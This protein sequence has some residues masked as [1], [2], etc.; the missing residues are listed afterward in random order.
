LPEAITDHQQ[1]FSINDQMPGKTFASMLNETL[2]YDYAVQGEWEKAAEF[3]RQGYNPEKH[4]T[5][6]WLERNFPLHIKIL[7]AA[8]EMAQAHRELVDY[9]RITG[10][11]T[12]YRLQV[13]EARAYLFVA[14]NKSEA[15]TGLLEE[16]A[17]QFQILDMSGESWRLYQTLTGLYARL[18]NPAKM[19]ETTYKAISIIDKLMASLPYQYRRGLQ[20][21]K[22]KGF[23]E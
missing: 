2:G 16:V 18:D 6:L 7:V 20:A 22:N 12:F 4:G 21:V 9:Q 11:T 10:S 15:A 14:E 5:F 17:Q 3:V 19:Q 13:K 1:A 23:F 8:G